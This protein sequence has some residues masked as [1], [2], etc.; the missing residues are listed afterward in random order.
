MP[1]D[2]S[3]HRQPL[4]LS[5]PLN[6]LLCTA[7]AEQ[8]TIKF[9]ARLREALLLRAPASPTQGLLGRRWSRK[10]IPRNTEGL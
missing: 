1:F 8:G 7:I 4:R 9:Y 5:V 2:S 10:F 3:T 6:D